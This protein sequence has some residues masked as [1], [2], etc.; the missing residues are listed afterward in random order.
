MKILITG[1]S[2][3]VGSR[4]ADCYQKKYE[5]WTP[6]HRELDIT[7]EAR[8]LEAV[9]SF[10]PA[11]AVHCGAV[12]DV[13]A[14]AQN[15]AL[16]Y[17][18]NVKGTQHLARACARAGARFVFCS[19]DQV[20]FRARGTEEG[21]ADFLAPHGEDEALA[22]LPLYGQH[23][24]MAERYALSEQPDSVILRL[25]WMYGELT[26]A[27]RKKGR[28]NLWTM[29]KEAVQ[30]QGPLAFSET[31]YRGVTDVAE[32]VRNMEAAWELPAGIYNF[33]SSND[34]DMYETVRRAMAAAG[35]EA[36]VKRAEGGALRNLTMDISKLE[37]NGVRFSDSAE[38][39]G[40]LLAH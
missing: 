16:S 40:S 11:V 34:A 8:T 26:E 27:E 5:I 33:G 29:L 30:T 15:P 19:S 14:C 24:R 23:K 21:T 7:D 20:Y 22:P 32:V 37:K 6:S 13:N 18:V 9:E 31:D 28:R 17:A 35:Q 12:S 4:L 10:R 25:T 1:S 39:L 38:R 36:L 2:G 3:F